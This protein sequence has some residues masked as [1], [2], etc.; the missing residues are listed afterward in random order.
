[1]F[2]LKEL[3]SKLEFL[4][5][6]AEATLANLNMLH[7]RVKTAAFVVVNDY[8]LI[9]SVAIVRE[10]ARGDTVADI[11][12]KQIYVSCFDEALH[13]AKPIVA[14]DGEINTIATVKSVLRFTE[15]QFENA[16]WDDFPQLRVLD[17]FASRR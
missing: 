16:V 8:D 14:S 6:E 10:C 2:D 15:A 11:A 1:M 5:N 17:E 4:A 12:T 13:L 7:K 9:N 3:I